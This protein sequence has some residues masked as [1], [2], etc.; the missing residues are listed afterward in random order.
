MDALSTSADWDTLKQAI[1]KLGNEG[2]LSVGQVKIA[3]EEGEK[4]VNRVEGITAKQLANKLNAIIPDECGII[5]YS[6]WVHIDTRTKA[7]RKGV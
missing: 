7:Y 1:I 5:V 6:T 2:A 4:A 3:L